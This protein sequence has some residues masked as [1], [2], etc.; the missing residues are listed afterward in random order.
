[1]AGKASKAHKGHR[2]GV[3]RKPKLDQVRND[4]N[5]TPLVDVC[6]VLLIIFMV[7][8]PLMARGQ[9]VPLPKTKYHSQKK[10][11]HQPVVAVACD[12]GGDIL[13]YDRDKLG[14]VAPAAL[15][16][17]KTN[18]ER[19]WETKPETQGQI[20][21]KAGD[22]CDYGHVYKVLIMINEE[23]GVQSIDLATADANRD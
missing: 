21:V 3:G 2:H 6:L 8:T 11:A 17:M 10:D 14:P 15:E 13:Y 7:V 19:A 12:D 5:V 16:K 4:I 22:H 9:E 18:V 1:M 23:L 20:Y